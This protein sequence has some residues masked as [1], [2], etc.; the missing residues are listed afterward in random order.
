M[1]LLALSLSIG[2]AIGGLGGIQGEHIHSLQ[3]DN[4][5]EVV[6]VE[7]HAN[8]FVAL[9]AVVHAGSLDEEAGTAGSS[10]FLE[11]LLFNGTAQMDQRELYDAVDRIGAYNNASTR[12]DHTVFMI[13]APSMHLG[14]A[15]RIQSQM[16]FHS[17][18]RQESIE[19]ERGVVSEEIR[20]DR[21]RES[22]RVGIELDHVLYR[23]TRLSTSVLG[24]VADIEGLPAEKV[25]SY[26][27]RNYVPSNVTLLVVGD[28]VPAELR[29]VLS[30]T[31]GQAI[32]GKKT[33][34]APFRV[35]ARNELHTFSV[36]A[37]KIY[38]KAVLPGPQA[39]SSEAVALSILGELWNEGALTNDEKPTLRASLRQL[40]GQAFLEFQ[41][42]I[43]AG[44]SPDE[45]LHQF[46]LNLRSAGGVTPG[47]EVVDR[48]V[49][50][51]RVA[52][53]GLLERPHYYG[54]MRADAIAAG[55][56]QSALDRIKALRQVS[57]ELLNQVAEK[58]LAGAPIQ[59]VAAG[60]GLRQRRADLAPLPAFTRSTPANMEPKP[61]S[62]R[63][64]T[65]VV[66]EVL[67][68]GLVVLIE[69]DPTAELAALHVLARNRSA[70][71]IRGKEGIADFLH[72]LLTQGTENRTA[73]VLS[74]EL[75]NMGAN[76][77]VTDE[78]WIPY[79]DYYF[80]PGFSYIRLETL[81]EDCSDA[82]QLLADMV[83]HPIFPAEEVESVRKLMLGLIGQR[84]TEARAQARAAFKAVLFGNHPLA[85]SPLGTSESISSIS[86]DDLISFHGTYFAPDNLVLSVVS[87]LPA[88]QVLAS[89]RQHFGA[90]RRVGS[91]APLPLLRTPTP[92][93]RRVLNIGRDQSVLYFGKLLSVRDEDWPALFAANAVLTDRMS[94][95]L[96]EREGL[97][98]SVGSSLK[99][100]SA[101][102]WLTV[103]A[104]TSPDQSERLEKLAKA[105]IDRL[106]RGISQQELDRAVGKLVGR[107]LM[108]RLPSISRAYYLGL[109]ELD[110][111]KPREDLDLLEAIQLVSPKEVRDV[112]KRYLSS[113]DL[114]AVEAR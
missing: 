109:G 14:E 76:L 19:K 56:I 9:T 86:R 88:G 101:G 114:V 30:M 91:S 90:A 31:Y 11:H 111:K 99:R 108:R 62:A 1:S 94:F 72:R 28:I 83:I 37:D 23:G 50:K 55:G 92:G 15:A 46:R 79:D 82:L 16:L 7:N 104:G 51:A 80:S 96:R 110:G 47:R 95:N 66:R 6:L 61:P 44:E 69:T 12:P 32:A 93:A 20:K 41:G 67:S 27:K 40:R 33:R 43:S 10:H 42:T 74:T 29:K 5:L 100:T 73:E 26:Y 8:P 54:L 34:E 57:P 64:R 102:S 18:L 105:E 35:E 84:E 103:A 58:W 85:R 13:L 68:N 75:D 22:Y 49:R 89:I 63:P 39:G 36:K 106:P 78:S 98:Y 70:M 17:T 48:R 25:R 113:D 3:L 107:A 59:A 81:A 87:S 2:L 21:D 60:S 65:K 77:K 53:A 52:E 71:E 112:A 24:S 45:A 4:G 38:L 97:A